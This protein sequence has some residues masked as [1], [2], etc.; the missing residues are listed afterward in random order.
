MIFISDLH[1]GS[2]NARPALLHKFLSE[3]PKDQTINIVGDGIDGWEIRKRGFGSWKSQTNHCLE[4]IL[5]FA[6][7]RLFVGN[8][9][10]FLYNYIGK[11]GN[12]RILEEDIIEIGSYRF[13]VLHGHIFDGFIA[14]AKLFYSLGSILYGWI[15]F[16][17]RRY[18]W[19]R[20]K[21]GLRYWSLSKKLKQSVKQAVKVVTKYEEVVVRYAKDKG[22][23][24]IIVGHC[25]HADIKLL[26]GVWYVNCG[27]WVEDSTFV[28]ANENSIQLC[29]YND[30]SKILKELGNLNVRDGA[31]LY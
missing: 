25:H 5:A 28:L 20:R 4:Q 26:N 15:M 1:L 3:V 9:D 16:M 12:L 18:N 19:F 6:K 24:G 13:L 29:S 14:R 10:E 27:D 23:D 2:K 21:L 7:I 17:N 31:K 8:H 30:G 11:Y 22:V